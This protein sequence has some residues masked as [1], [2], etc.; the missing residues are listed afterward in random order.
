MDTRL[1]QIPVTATVTQNGSTTVLVQIAEP[2]FTLIRWRPFLYLAA[3]GPLLSTT[4][5]QEQVTVSLKDKDSEAYYTRGGVDYWG[6]QDWDQS[7]DWYG[8]FW[9]GKHQ[10]EFTFAR[11]NLLNLTSANY[12]ISLLM[13]G[14]LGS[15]PVFSPRS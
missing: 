15:T 14:Y 8:Q 1:F 2:G 4:A 12:F 9:P 6:L 5:S 7:E 3:T 10:L 13:Q 11:T